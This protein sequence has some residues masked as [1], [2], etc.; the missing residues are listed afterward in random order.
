[1]FIGI[2]ISIVIWRMICICCMRGFGIV[3]WGGCW[4]MFKYKKG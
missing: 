2:I 4:M 3:I 1:M